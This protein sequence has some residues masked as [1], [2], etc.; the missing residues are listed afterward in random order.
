M[1]NQKEYLLHGGAQ[2]PNCAS[3]NV[4]SDSL[5]ADGDTVTAEARCRNCDATWT[6]FF[7]LAGYSDLKTHGEV[8]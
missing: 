5:D 8:K 4:E 3:T 2:C 6:E 1:M 7:R